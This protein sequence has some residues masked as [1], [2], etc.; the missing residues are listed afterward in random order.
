MDTISDYPTSI[1]E[2]LDNGGDLHDWNPREVLGWIAEDVIDARLN[3]GLESIDR[4][5][6]D[7]TRESYERHAPEIR[8]GA[9]TDPE[10]RE[11]AVSWLAHVRDME[12]IHAAYQ[13]EY[14]KDDALCQRIMDAMPAEVR[15]RHL[16][17]LEAERHP[18]RIRV[19]ERDLYRCDITG[20]I[21]NG[22]AVVLVPISYMRDALE[23]ARD[24]PEIV[25]S[26]AAILGAL[27]E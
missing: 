8:D 12:L 21:E 6:P 1:R 15:E 11:M 22:R 2:H 27:G 23:S 3:S 13:S 7:Q 9:W 17:G 19:E 4:R 25:I 26:P 18:F 5:D 14:A 20:E 10:N 16:E 24:V